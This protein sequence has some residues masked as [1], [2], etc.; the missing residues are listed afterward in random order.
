M[1]IWKNEGIDLGKGNA[2]SETQH[3]VRLVLKKFQEG[4]TRREVSEIDFYMEEWFSKA[5]DTLVV[6]TADSVQFDLQRY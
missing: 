6:G 4:Y 5:G 1:L 3:E 2:A